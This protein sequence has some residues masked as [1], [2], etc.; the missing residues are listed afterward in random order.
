MSRARSKQ[1]RPNSRGASRLVISN[2]TWRVQLSQLWGAKCRMLTSPPRTMFSKKVTWRVWRGPATRP[3]NGQ[4]TG[5]AEEGGEKTG[6]NRGYYRGHS[7][8]WKGLMRGYRPAQLERT[9]WGTT[10]HRRG[11]GGGG[12]GGGSA[13]ARSISFSWNNSAALAGISAILTFRVRWPG[14]YCTCTYTQPC[15][16]LLS[17]VISQ[18]SQRHGQRTWFVRCK[19]HSRDLCNRVAPPSLTLSSFH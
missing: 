12:G 2:E 15:S 9:R 13:R 7:N 19:F 1:R 8:R 18:S 11:G 6:N 17:Q 14:K 3:L 4:N 10:I 16:G 5:G